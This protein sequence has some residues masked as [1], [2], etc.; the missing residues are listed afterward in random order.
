M[1]QTSELCYIFFFILCTHLRGCFFYFFHGRRTDVRLFSLFFFYP[2][3]VPSTVSPFFSHDISF[4]MNQYCV[5][6]FKCCTDGGFST[7]LFV[8]LCSIRFLFSVSDG[9]TKFSSSDF[10]V[11][12]CVRTEVM[13][14]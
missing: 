4:V 8:I 7:L 11:F 12:S 13:K 5:F 2:K 6:F 14:S 9:Y 10:F 3:V 1:H